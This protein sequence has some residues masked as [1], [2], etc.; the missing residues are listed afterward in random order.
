MAD[1]DTVNLIVVGNEVSERALSIA[2]AVDR[3]PPGYVY[4]L[5]I[6]KPDLPALPWHVEIA[7]EERLSVFRLTYHPE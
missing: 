2:R 3:L 1:Q 4:H 5:E 7:R 6:A